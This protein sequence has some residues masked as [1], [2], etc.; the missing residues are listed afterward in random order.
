MNTQ[1]ICCIEFNVEKWDNK[2][3]V[4]DKKPFIKETI[5]TLFH[6]PFPPMIGNKITKMMKYAEDAKMLDPNKEDTLILF[7]DPT[8]FKTIIYLGVTGVVP[9][10]NNTSLSGT[11]EAKVYDGSFN[12]VPKF[13]NDMNSKLVKNGKSKPKDSDYFIHFAYCPKCAEKYKHNYMILF[14]KVS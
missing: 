13:V 11:Y 14:A 10:A 3:F 7:Q 4:W 8:P 5:P 12:D 6:I 1:D 9:N 2:T